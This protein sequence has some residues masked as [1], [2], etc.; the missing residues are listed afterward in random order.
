MAKKPTITEY[1]KQWKENLIKEKGNFEFEYTV[2]TY[3]WYDVKKVSLGWEDY[4][5]YRLERRF[6]CSL[7]EFWLIGVNVQ[8]NDRYYLDETDLGRLHPVDVARFIKWCEFEHPS[9]F[10]GQK[11]SIGSKILTLKVISTEYN[12]MEEMKFLVEQW[13]KNRDD[14]QV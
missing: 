14:G 2:P 1:N 12:I 11:G 4:N 6:G 13:E 5:F 9:C 10:E 3:D 7:G 8:S